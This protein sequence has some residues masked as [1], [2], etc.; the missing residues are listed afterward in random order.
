M[1]P[2]PPYPPCNST[3][4]AP[5][6]TKPY[7]IST[8]PAFASTF[9]NSGLICSGS[10][11]PNWPNS[12]TV[13]TPLSLLYNSPGLV[14]NSRYITLSFVLSFPT[15]DILLKYAGLPSVILI[16]KFIVSFSAEISTGFILENKYP[17]FW[18]KLV[19]SSPSGFV[20]SAILF[21]VKHH[22]IHHP[23]KD[24]KILLKIHLNKLYSRES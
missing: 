13:R 4:L 21:L 8:V 22:Y 9:L 19:I 12:L 15:T 14:R 3:W 18:Y 1:N 17:L 5:F 24:L 6:S 23:W 20:S 10:K 11:N 2:P 7:S 16:S